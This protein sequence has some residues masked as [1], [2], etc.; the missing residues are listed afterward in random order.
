[1]VLE[2]GTIWSLPLEILSE[3]GQVIE[4]SVSAG[5]VPLA[6]HRVR[7]RAFTVMVTQGRLRIEAAFV[8]TVLEAGDSAVVSAGVP[9]RL[10][11][12]A[13]SPTTFLVFICGEWDGKL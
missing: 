8:G 9:H 11:G 13:E 5:S 7:D 6:R 3:I 4:V 10:V 12:L 1:M 2:D